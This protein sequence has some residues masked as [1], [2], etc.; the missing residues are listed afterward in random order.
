MATKQEI[1]KLLSLIFSAFSKT[2]VRQEQVELYHAL[3]GHIGID[4]LKLAVHRMLL[5]Q[6]FEPKPADLAE[7]ITAV[8]LPEHRAPTTCAAFVVIS[9]AQSQEARK[10]LPPLLRDTAKAFSLA[11]MEEGS[12]TVRAQFLKL[13]AEEKAARLVEMLL[14]DITRHQLSE[15]RSSFKPPK[16]NESNQDGECLKQQTTQRNP[17]AKIQIYND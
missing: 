4:V 1:T 15:V 13:Y 5:T 12:A 7:A 14:P 3:F 17:Y 11:E 2:E 10:K 16:R 6:R 9:E 8:W